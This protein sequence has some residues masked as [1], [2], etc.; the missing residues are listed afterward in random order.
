MYIPYV[1]MYRH[2]S[3][4]KVWRF[5]GQYLPSGERDTH[6]CSVWRYNLWPDSRAIKNKMIIF[7]R[8]QQK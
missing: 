2:L 4:I 7:R 1:H 5:W 3:G 8:K 6:T